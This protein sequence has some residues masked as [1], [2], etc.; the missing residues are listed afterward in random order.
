MEM[1]PISWSTSAD[2]P[3][4]LEASVGVSHILGVRSP[5]PHDP[6]PI[7]HVFHENIYLRNA[8][9]VT[10]TDIS[11]GSNGRPIAFDKRFSE[12]G[13]ACKAAVS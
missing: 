10:R 13:T 11:V 3:L 6:V 9:F 2:C 8:L 5:L 1:N 12:T 4:Q 7:L